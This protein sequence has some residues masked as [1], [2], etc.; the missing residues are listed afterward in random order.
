MKIF[1]FLLFTFV[2]TT[3]TELYLI[4]EI[5][6]TIGWPRTI[7][8]TLLTGETNFLKDKPVFGKRLLPKATLLLPD[9]L[10]AYPQLRIC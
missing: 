9:Q 4:I 10:E 7:A 6:D 8:W 2:L 5:S 3:L 1:S